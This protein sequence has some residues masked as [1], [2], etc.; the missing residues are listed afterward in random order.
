M[1]L[2]WAFV[3]VFYFIGL[4]GFEVKY[5]IEEKLKYLNYFSGEVIQ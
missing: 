5:Y 4:A 1:A 2:L 3:F